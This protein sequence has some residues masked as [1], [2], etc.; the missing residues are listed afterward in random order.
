MKTQKRRPAPALSPGDVRAAYIEQREWFEARLSRNPE[1]RKYHP[2]PR[3]DGGRAMGRQHQPVWPGLAQKLSA[4]GITNAKAYMEW[5]FRHQKHSQPP[6]PNAIA[7]DRLLTAY[8]ETNVEA[9][10]ELD[11]TIALNGQRHVFE[12]KVSIALDAP[13]AISWTRQEVERYVLLDLNTE[14]S[15]LFRYLVAKRLE[16]DDV[17]EMFQAA[18]KAQFRRSPDAYRKTWASLLKEHPGG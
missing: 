7:S 6:W 12:T 14:L 8:R 13:Y 2:G 3:W 16:L 1:V 9:E 5:V 10:N 17:M 11:L 15:S 4:A 18:A